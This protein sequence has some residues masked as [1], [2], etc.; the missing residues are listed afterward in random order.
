MVFLQLIG[1]AT[2][3][4]HVEQILYSPSNQSYLMQ[5]QI[6]KLDR[7][8]RQQNTIFAGSWGKK[9]QLGGSLGL[10]FAE[11]FFLRHSEQ[12]APRPLRNPLMKCLRQRILLHC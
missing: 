2:Q 3:R 4:H 12:S 5:A 1:D 9:F 6:I 7:K 8:Y 11:E 10:L